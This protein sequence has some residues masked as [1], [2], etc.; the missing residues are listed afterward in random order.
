METEYLPDE[1][2]IELGKIVKAWITFEG[3][4]DLMLQKLAGFDDPFDPTF[5]ILTAHSSF[6]QKLDMFKSLCARHLPSRGH[7]QDYK[8]VAALIAEAQRLRN[9][10]MH[11]LIGPG[12]DGPMR[13]STVSA[14]GE[15]KMQVRTIEL[16]EVRSAHEKITAAGRS[17]YRLVL[18]TDPWADDSSTG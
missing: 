12:M 9:F 17:V 14:R 4:F 13:V 1:W 18:N 2:L 6:P 8:T 10:Y 3:L 15:L 5:T 11:N 16:A 7:L